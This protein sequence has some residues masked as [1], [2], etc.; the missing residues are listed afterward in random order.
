M[1]MSLI[2]EGKNG[3]L[4]KLLIVLRTK[5]YVP[6]KNLVYGRFFF[7]NYLNNWFS[8]CTENKYLMK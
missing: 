5:L 3:I 4:L 6:A 8:S 7:I 2:I 1:L